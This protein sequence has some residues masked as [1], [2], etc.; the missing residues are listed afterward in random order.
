LAKKIVIL[1]ATGSIGTQTL[2]VARAC[3][4]R[5]QVVGLSAHRHWQE[6][7]ELARI[8]RPRWV[9]LTDLELC[10]SIDAEALERPST[11]LWGS[12]GVERMATDPSVDVVVSAMVGAAGLR[13]TLA[14]LEAGKNV[15]LANKETLV[16]AG[17][18]VKAVANRRGVALMPI[19][20][21][22]SAIFQCL[23][24]GRRSEA[25]RLILTASGGPFRT[26]PIARL[27]SVTAEEALRHPT[28]QMGKK[29]TIDSAT[30]MNKAL[31]IIE[32]HYLFD[33]PPERIEVL[34]H[35]QSM[36]HS[37]VEFVDGSVLA[38]ISPPD[39]RLPIQYAL[40]FPERWPGPSRRWDLT[41]SQNWTFE[42]PDPA[43]YPALRLGYEVVRLGGTAGAALNAAN[44]VA[45]ASFLDGRIRFPDI[46]CLC[47]D[48]LDHHPF[49]S[50]PT[51]E[52]LYWVDRWAR[53]EAQNW[54]RSAS[55][56]S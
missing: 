11:L 45:V 16:V 48:V 14:A 25:V 49:D 17:P 1:G 39:M 7:F 43:R 3:P 28:W 21:E 24:G 41:A 6:L 42:P 56:R 26:T 19:D 27:E 10:E 29:I 30:M 51:L 8:H 22:H 18:L 55:L 36:V 40:S 15:A 44:E 50:N 4:D 32:A 23:Q 46:V 31:E 34:I 33:L 9:A 54:T 20:S 2:D 5:I 53:L 13:G 47:R 12:E 37:L 38:Q 35:P 52:E